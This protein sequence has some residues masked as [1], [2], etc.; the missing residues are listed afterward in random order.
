MHFVYNTCE[1]PWIRSKTRVFD[2]ITGII[3]ACT[4][5]INSAR[6]NTWKMIG[7]SHQIR[8]KV[9]FSRNPKLRW[10]HTVFCHSPTG[11]ARCAIFELEPVCTHTQRHN[12]CDTV[13]PS[14]RFSAYGYCVWIKTSLKHTFPQRRIGTIVALCAGV[15]FV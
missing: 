14:N 5:T 1:K 13:L 12:L 7:S 10:S 3:S 4:W 8:K 9:Y 11:Y 15:F 2:R 6:K